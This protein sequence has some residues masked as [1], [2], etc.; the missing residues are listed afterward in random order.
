LAQLEAL[1]KAEEEEKRKAELLEKERIEK[2]VAKK[3]AERL[4]KERIEKDLAKKEAERLERE[5]MY[6]LK[7]RAD[8]AVLNEQN[9]FNDFESISVT[10]HTSPP[11]F[12]K[13]TV[14][15]AGNRYLY[16]V[17][18]KPN[19]YPHCKEIHT[20][21]LTK[22]E[23]LKKDAYYHNLN[24]KISDCIQVNT[25]IINLSDKQSDLIKKMILLAEKKTSKLEKSLAD[26]KTV[27]EKIEMIS[28]FPVD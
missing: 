12:S 16:V 17:S 24:N 10:K 27:E 28:G 22:I 26:A 20:S 21:F 4:E 23:K 25:E 2:E 14:E 8:S 15:N 9:L 1:R 18:K 11:S 13:Y 3:E 6:Q 19:F 5:K 7:N